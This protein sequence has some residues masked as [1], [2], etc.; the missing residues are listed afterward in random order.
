MRFLL[1]QAIMGWLCHVCGASACSNNVRKQTGR[2]FR[3]AD[4]KAP[5]AFLT[6]DLLWKIE[7]CLSASDSTFW[8]PCLHTIYT[9]SVTI[10]ACS[11]TC[12]FIG[13]HFFG[14]KICSQDEKK[15]TFDFLFYCKGHYVVW[16]CTVPA[17][18]KSHSHNRPSENNRIFI[19]LFTASC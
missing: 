14:P 5:K 13:W 3:F 15:H 2:C 10:M 7:A 4:R 17:C 11:N 18:L 1:S 6:L 19:P 12:C 16:H 8:D 9:L